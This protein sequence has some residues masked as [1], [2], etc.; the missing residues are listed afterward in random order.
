MLVAQIVATIVR[1]APTNELASSSM[2]SAVIFRESIYDQHSTNLFPSSAAASVV[3]QSSIS[4][5]ASELPVPALSTIPPVALPAGSPTDSSSSLPLM[6]KPNAVDLNSSSLPSTVSASSSTLSLSSLPPGSLEK[7][8]LPPHMRAEKAQQKEKAARRRSG[9]STPV[10]SS[11]SSL[12]SSSSS[13]GYAGSSILVPM[14]IAGSIANAS[15]ASASAVA[16]GAGAAAAA[17]AGAGMLGSSPQSGA[18]DRAIPTGT[19]TAAAAQALLSSPSTAR[20]GNSS[21]STSGGV[22]AKAR[23]SSSGSSTPKKLSR[24]AQSK[25][26]QAA[27]QLAQHQYMMQQQQFQQLQYQQYQQFLRQ[28]AAQMQTRVQALAA[29]S[30][31]AAAASPSPALASSASMSAA[32]SSSPSTLLV[33]MGISRSSSHNDVASAAAITPADAAIAAINNSPLLQSGVAAHA[34]GASGGTRT[35]A[36]TQIDDRIREFEAIRALCEHNLAAL[37]VL[38]AQYFEPVGGAGV[39]GGA[40]AEGGT[41]GGTL[42]H[43]HQAGAGASGSTSGS[44]GASGS[45]SGSAGPG[46]AAGRRNSRSSDALLVDDVPNGTGAGASDIGDIDDDTGGDF[47]TGRHRNVLLSRVSNRA[48]GGGAVGDGDALALPYPARRQFPGSVSGTE[49]PFGRPFGGV[50]GSATTALFQPMIGSGLLSVSRG[51]GG[52]GLGAH[53]RHGALSAQQS[54][55]G[56]NTPLEHEHELDFEQITQRLASIVHSSALESAARRRAGASEREIEGEGDGGADASASADADADADDIDV[57]HITDAVLANADVD[58]DGDE[59]DLASSHDAHRY[60]HDG[61]SGSSV[62]ASVSASASPSPDV[63]RMRDGGDQSMVVAASARKRG[64]VAAATAIAGVGSAAS[65]EAVSAVPFASSSLASSS[66]SQFAIN[67][68]PVASSN[69][70]APT[71]KRLV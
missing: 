68:F 32:V 19:V 16:A 34:A 38:R 7:S 65:D 57:S 60:R 58:A 46:S 29:S 22:S 5:A 45:A 56:M 69:A 12:V 44:R 6:P 40:V 30:P 66:A 4:S 35:T 28:Q 3:A 39:S 59:I 51:G 48:L 71:P 55:S 53:P 1:H 36:L 49:S 31:A 11:P 13:E 24:Q 27:V 50:G 41:L 14:P 70:A 26:Q 61:S 2:S 25:L 52:G 18:K 15:P 54:E 43:H 47:E 63:Q 67:L 9:T 64:S 8:S 10:P 37:A 20:T 62:S 23:G 33:P 17:A 21:A 42:P